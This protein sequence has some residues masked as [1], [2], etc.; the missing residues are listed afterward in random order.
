MEGVKEEQYRT[1]VSPGIR[2]QLLNV[3]SGR[4]EMDFVVEGDDRSMHVLNAVS[5]GFTCAIPFAEYVGARVQSAVGQGRCS[6]RFLNV[7]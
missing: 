2:A 6:G 1:W 5:P 7:C 3:Q 4:L